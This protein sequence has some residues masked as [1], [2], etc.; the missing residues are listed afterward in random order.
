[1]TIKK[2]LITTTLFTVCTLG[3]HS[4]YA[5]SSSC[6]VNLQADMKF[7]PDKIEFFDGN[8]K[9]YSIT[10]NKTLMVKGN[11]VPLNDYQQKLVTDFSLSIRETVPEVKA[12]AIEGVN[13]AIDGVNLA[14][15]EL[16]GQG[17]SVSADVTEQL[18]IVRDELDER[19]ADESTYVIDRDGEIV[20]D[21]L[22]KDFENRIETAVEKAVTQSMG[23][24]LMVVGKEMLMSGGDT[25][26]FETK[27]ESFGN[28][29]EQEM[30]L[31]AAKLEQ[32]AEGLCQ[33]AVEINAIE[34][35]MT[36]AIE[37]LQSYDVI[38]VSASSSD[39]V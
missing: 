37:Q 29:I 10:D 23:T 3:A 36:N 12:I 14:F 6:N 18:T 30:E 26:A 11:V 39:S 22:G 4:A 9:Y 27:M 38:K 15:N 32:K 25:K 20:D 13:L 16:L 2:S 8:K 24:L 28:Q 21:V 31:R 17:N 33:S 5:H 35:E 34:T 19:F 7:S 1:M